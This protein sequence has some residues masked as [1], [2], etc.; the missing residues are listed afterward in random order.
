MDGI[1]TQPQ[2][3]KLTNDNIPYIHYIGGRCHWLAYYWLA[4]QFDN[5]PFNAK[6]TIRNS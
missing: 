3:K 1:N 5:T 4:F 2:I 6:K